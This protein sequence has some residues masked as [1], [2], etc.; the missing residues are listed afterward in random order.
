MEERRPLV[1]VIVPNYN[2]ARTLDLCLSALE[3]QTYP[4]I[5]VIVVDDRSTDDSVQIAHRHGVRVV[6][7]DTN[8]GAPAARN[9]GVRHAR[10]EVLFFLDSD[11]ALA[12]DV[13]EHAVDLLTSDPTLGVVCGT[14]D[15]E[16]LIPDSRVERYR[17]LQLHYWISGDEGDITTIY[18]ALFA[19][20]AEV[21]H[22]VGP[23]NPALRHSENAEYG[24][25]LTRLGYR[26]VLDNRIRGRHDHDDRLRVVLSKFFHRAR[27]HI[28]LYLRRPDF[29]GG[30][31]NSSR[32]WGSLAALF[33]VLAVPLPVLLGPVWALVPVAL[34]LGSIASDLGMYRFVRRYAG[35]PFALYFTAVHFLVNVTVGVAV[36]VGAA[37]C[38]L[39]SEFRR[40]YDVPGPSA[41][42]GV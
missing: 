1:S 8:I 21:F 35:L 2:Y 13:V 14:Y 25:R 12:E 22:E 31:A 36:F 4:D 18:S 24:H 32:G 27:L 7:T 15:P 29:N 39:S 40:T 28:P 26:I 23:L 33:A 34:L 5:E 42:V 16:P 9:V 11:L 37:H 30:P 17:S 6:V 19:M 3:R 38:L 10:G 41:P 20:R